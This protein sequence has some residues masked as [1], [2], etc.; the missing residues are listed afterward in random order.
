MQKKADSRIQKLKEMNF[1][2]T[3]ANSYN[4][5]LEKVPAYVRKKVALKSVMPSSES[6]VARWVLGED[7]EK[8][9]EIQ[10]NDIP[11]IKD[12]PD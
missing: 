7:D 1:T 11:F 10:S 9:P 8:N 4:E 5:D 3:N 6:N 12:K 2:N